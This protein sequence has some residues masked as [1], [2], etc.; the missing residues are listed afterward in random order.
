MRRLQTDR[1]TQVASAGHAF[2]QNLR[3]GHLELGMDASSALRIEEAFNDLARA[4]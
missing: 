4:I 1:T 2:V 3:R